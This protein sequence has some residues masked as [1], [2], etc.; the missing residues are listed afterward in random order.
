MGEKSQGGFR[1]F[2]R[3]GD[4]PPQWD[5]ADRN[6]FLKRDVLSILEKVNPCQQEYYLH[7]EKRILFVTYRLKLDVFSFQS[8]FS[9]KIPVRILGIPLSLSCSGYLCPKEELEFF[10]RTL[11]K[12]P[13]LLIL[14]TEKE[15]DLPTARTLGTYELDLTKEI[16]FRATAE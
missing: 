1:S 5:I 15:L 12:F 10:S 13:L 7:S 11:D 6:N 16:V 9:L 2:T 8:G 3:V 14:N 4:I